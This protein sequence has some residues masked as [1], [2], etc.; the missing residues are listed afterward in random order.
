MQAHKSITAKDI[1]EN[2]DYLA[3]SYGG[4]RK[5]SREFQPTVKQLKEDLRILQAM[6][7]KVLRTYNVQLAQASN[8]LKAIKQLMH[9]E[10]NF[11]M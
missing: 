3:I 11:E 1:L 5:T 10:S 2:P 7:I 4:Y 8:L 6:N 9:E